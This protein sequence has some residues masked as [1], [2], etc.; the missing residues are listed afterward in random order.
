MLFVT[1]GSGFVG[2]TLIAEAVTRGIAVRALARS[3]AAEATVRACGGEPVRGDLDDVNALRAG[4]TGC[5]AVIHT[6]AVVDEWGDPA[7]FHRVNVAGTR[8]AL[9]A[10]A[11]AGVR[12]FVHISTAWVLAGPS[13][14]VQVKETATRPAAPYGLY[15]L[16]KGLAEDEVRSA[17]G[18]DLSTVII[19]PPII[20][21]RGDTSVLPKIVAA[22]RAGRFRWIDGGHYLISATHVANVAEAALLATERGLRRGNI[23][24]HRWRADRVPPVRD[25][26]ARNARCGRDRPQ[27]AARRRP[28][29]GGRDRIALAAAPPHLDAP[30][31]PDDSENDGRRGDVRR[32]EGTP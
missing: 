5:D 24:R 7:L 16:T 3:A 27:R 4:M 8:H 9:V 6:A 10:A 13:S 19:R 15:A 22:V 23:F 14:F 1:G 32:L 28:R 30:G 17:N 12:R 26:T 21:G 11:G 20:W 18:T 2:R 25:G 29:R 31:Q